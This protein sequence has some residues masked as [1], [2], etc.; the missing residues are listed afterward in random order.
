MGRP[1]AAAAVLALALCHAGGT[2]TIPTTP[3]PRPTSS[4]QRL[5][6]QHTGAAGALSRAEQHGQTAPQLR[7]DAGQNCSIVLQSAIDRATASGVV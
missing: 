3:T 4:L 6:E 2:A 5:E 7:C 1:R